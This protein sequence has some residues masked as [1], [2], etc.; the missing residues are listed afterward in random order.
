MKSS[1]IVIIVIAIVIIGGVVGYL[2]FNGYFGNNQRGNSNGP[3]QRRNFQMNQ[4]QID[5]VTNFFS[6]NP[7]SDEI[8]TYCSTNRG[9]CMYYCRNVNQENDYCKQ[10][11][12]TRMRGNYS[13]NQG[14]Q[15]PQ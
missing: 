10:L 9:E 5:D 15:P 7:T 8:Q 13:R 2:Y 6:T 11:N 14:G 12:A 4:T 1:I 3:G